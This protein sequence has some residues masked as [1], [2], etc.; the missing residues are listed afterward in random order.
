[1]IDCYYNLGV[2][3]LQRGDTVSAAEMF[4]EA[5]HLRPNDR[6]LQRLSRFAKAYQQR[7]QDLLYRIFVKYL[8][9][10]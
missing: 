1:M 5:Q 2:R 8:P 10:H 4:D 6:E 7:S 3:D 9:F